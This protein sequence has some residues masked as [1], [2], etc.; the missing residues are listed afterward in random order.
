MLVERGSNSRCNKLF[1]GYNEETYKANKHWRVAQRPRWSNTDESELV[2]SDVKVM[3]ISGMN[4]ELNNEQES[5]NEHHTIT[6]RGT[7]T[8]DSKT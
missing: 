1:I 2:Q 3:V 5:R 6:G 8:P 7:G 4:N